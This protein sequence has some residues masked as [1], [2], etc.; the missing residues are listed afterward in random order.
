MTPDL[1]DTPGRGVGVVVPTRSTPTNMT[2]SPSQIRAMSSGVDT[3][4]PSVRGEQSVVE[5]LSP[6]AA[7][8]VVRVDECDSSGRSTVR[9]NRAL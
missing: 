4:N 9:R 8:P 7:I 3:R 6:A 2:T 5:R 1:G